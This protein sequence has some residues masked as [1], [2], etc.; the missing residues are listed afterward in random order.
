M[1]YQKKILAIKGA[2]SQ[3]SQPN[4]Y[5]TEPNLDYASKIRFI[6]KCPCSPDSI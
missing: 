6:K 1:F 2:L 3:Q 4:L 5:L